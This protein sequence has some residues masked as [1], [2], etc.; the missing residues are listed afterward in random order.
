[1]D[2]N[3]I[4]IRA[5]LDA[6]DIGVFIL[7]ADGYYLYVN[8]AHRDIARKPKEFF[9]GMSIQQLKEDG[10]LSCSVWEKVVQTRKP[11]SSVLK[12]TDKANNRCYDALTVGWP[13]FDVQGTLQYIL[14]T[15]ETLPHLNNRLQKGMMNK[16]T[17]LVDSVD[18]PSVAPVGIIA[19]SPQMKQLMALLSIVSKTDASVLVSG[20]S[21]SGKEVVGRHIHRTSQR[22]KKPFVALNCAA[23]PESLMESELF[24]YERGAFTGAAPQGKVGLLEAANG[25]TLFLDEI[26]SMPLSLQAKLLRVLETQQVTR[27]GAV[28]AKK[29]DFRLICTSNEDL[30]LLIS[31]KR[32]R[33]DLLY[34]INVISIVIPPLQERREDIIPLALH[35]LQHYCQKYSCI[36]VFTDRILNEMKALD[37]PGNVRELKNFVERMIVTS[38]MSEWLIETIPP[39]FL[40]EASEPSKAEWQTAQQVPPPNF[41]QDAGFSFSSYMEACER[42]LLEQ[43]LQELHSPAAVA[44]ALKLDLSNVYRKMKKYHLGRKA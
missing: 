43:A 40:G 25:G 35:Y 41:R 19:E 10:Y 15:Q 4:P 9:A 31:E 1:M 8:Q 33:A 12:I 28:T 20:P 3:H 27:V 21:G 24:G 17:M 39:A 30:H 16:A 13:Y 44:K 32:F 26:N 22:S 36:K 37:W 42:K 6:L 7:D 29:I 18:A 23:I 34:R 38:P 14:Y 2:M 5:I 11:V